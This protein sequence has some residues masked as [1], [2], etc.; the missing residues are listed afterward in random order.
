[1]NFHKTSNIYTIRDFTTLYPSLP[2]L[3]MEVII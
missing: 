3:T 1:M 2:L